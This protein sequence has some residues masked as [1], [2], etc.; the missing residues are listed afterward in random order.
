MFWQ[1]P[2]P[3]S[4]GYTVA[5]NGRLT[6]GTT[7]T[8]CNNSPIFY[9]TS[10]NTGVL[11]S[12]DSAAGKGQLLPQTTPAGGFTATTQAGTY[13]GGTADVVIQYQEVNNQVVTWGGTG[14]NVTENYVKDS[15]TV[16]GG[17]ADI[18]GIVPETTLAPT[19]L[20]SVT[21]S[22][23]GTQIVGI[24]VD[25]SHFLYVEGLVAGYP[26]AILFGP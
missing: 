13:F 1:T 14:T 7:G 21:G 26:S 8:N 9:L 11:I 3:I 10:L 6:L 18:L 23:T 16:G 25:S 19:G 24:A 22:L 2:A 20:I 17:V 12:T 15:V 5:T 4:C